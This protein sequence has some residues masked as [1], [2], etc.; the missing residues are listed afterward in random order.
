MD[1]NVDDGRISLHLYT[2]SLDNPRMSSYFDLHGTAE[3]MERIVAALEQGLMEVLRAHVN[4][5]ME[6]SNKVV[7]L[8]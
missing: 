5:D 4:K 8:P 6:A 7:A 3:Q 1:V 2:V